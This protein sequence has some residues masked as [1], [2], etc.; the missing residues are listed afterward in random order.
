MDMLV[1]LTKRRKKT[2]SIFATTHS[3]YVL[4]HLMQEQVPGLR[5]FFTHPVNDEEGYVVQQATDDEIQEIYDNGLD[6]FFNYE[7]FVK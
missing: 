3:P 1:N 2:V 7:A 5:L 6:M 4:T